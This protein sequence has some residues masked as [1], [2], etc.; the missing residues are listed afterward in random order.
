M[1]F[2]TLWPLVYLAQVQ[3]GEQLCSKSEGELARGLKALCH[4]VSFNFAVDKN[5]CF[6]V[7]KW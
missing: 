1:I 5:P 3:H 6:Y 7:E 4:H 2:I